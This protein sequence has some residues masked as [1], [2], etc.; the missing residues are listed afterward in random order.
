MENKENDG[1]GGKAKF[2]GKSKIKK[3]EFIF[4]MI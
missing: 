4:E 2:M 3:T 1:S